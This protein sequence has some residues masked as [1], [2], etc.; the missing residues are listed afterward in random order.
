M[1]DGAAR[2]ISD[3]QTEILPKVRA[4]LPRDHENVAGKV[5]GMMGKLPIA[6][7]EGLARD[8]AALAKATAQLRA[9]LPP[10]E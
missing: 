1:A 3:V 2:S 7:L 9:K 5:V 8:P 4:L 10:A 6:A